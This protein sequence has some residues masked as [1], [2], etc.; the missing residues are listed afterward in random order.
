MT[1]QTTL[2]AAG[3]IL[4]AGLALSGC[5]LRGKQAEKMETNT[6][7]T[8]KTSDAELLAAMAQL[9]TEMEAIAPTGTDLQDIQ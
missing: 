4:V 8:A 6:P 7:V 9:D 3:V 1:K 2:L 5:S